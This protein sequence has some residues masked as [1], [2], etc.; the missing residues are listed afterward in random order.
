MPGTAHHMHMAKTGSPGHFIREWR[1]HRDLTQ[2]QLA[3]RLGMTYQNLGKI[4]RGLVSY[5]QPL[6]EGL[7]DALNC[8]PADIIM[9]DPSKPDSIYS[10]WEQLEPAAKSQVVEIAKT[11]RKVG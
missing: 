11:F 7:A 3:E 2:E 1:K 8:T 6:L 5:T 9:R 10:I 4:E